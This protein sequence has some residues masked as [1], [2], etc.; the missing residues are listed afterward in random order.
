MQRIFWS[1]SIV[2][3][4][5]L[6]VYNSLAI[7]TLWKNVCIRS[8]SGPYFP[9]FKMNTERYG[10]SWMYGGHESSLKVSK[11]EKSLVF[12]YLSLYFS[13]CHIFLD[14][15]NFEYP[16]KLAYLRWCYV[17]LFDVH[18]N[19]PQKGVRRKF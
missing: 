19:S 17:C 16:W 12:K 4:H 7:H 11:T 6:S 5:L 1:H 9:A 2:L 14:F 13:F 8:F 15:L 10:L 3:L 18:Y